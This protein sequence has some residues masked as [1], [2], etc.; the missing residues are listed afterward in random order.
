[1]R[2][3]RLVNGILLGL[4]LGLSAAL[5]MLP[6]NDGDSSRLTGVDPDAVRAL[7]LTYPRAS[8]A[9]LELERR[10]DGWHLT[11][12][13]ARAARDGRIVT[14][15]EVLKAR[16][17]S[18][19]ELAAHDPAE[20]GLE[21][22]RLRLRIDDTTVAFGSRAADGRRYVAAGERLCLV[23][24][25]GYPLLAQGLDG[26]A[27]SG[28]LPQG[29]APLR[30]D[31]PEAAAARANARADWQLERGDQGRPVDLEAWAAHWRAAGAQ[32]FALS[33]G[34]GDHGRIRV[35]TTGGGIHRWRIAQREPE[36]VLV[37]A[38]ADYGLGIASE[39]AARL[40]H[41]PAP[42]NADAQDAPAGQR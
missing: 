7:T 42:S 37:P 2:R 18:C 33:P 20:F 5:W 11:R 22:P 3:R 8:S 15:L 16:T 14:A 17:D 10:D 27:A 25:R 12:P 24:D 21:S 13:I 35:E 29:A 6:G 32:S 38:D 34:D 28:L 1:M 4:A 36:L 40:L 31:T 19:Y 39:Q 26:L 23:A 41:P 9:R 30:I